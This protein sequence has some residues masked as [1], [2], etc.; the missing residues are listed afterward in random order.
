[1]VVGVVAVLLTAAQPVVGCWI[2]KSHAKEASSLGPAACLAD[3]KVSVLD[4]SALDGACQACIAKLDEIANTEDDRRMKKGM[5][6]CHMGPPGGLLWTASSGRYWIHRADGP[7]CD[8]ICDPTMEPQIGR[9]CEPVMC[10]GDKLAV[11]EDPPP[12]PGAAKFL[13]WE[14]YVCP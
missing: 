12:K 7:T 3:C 9:Y 2:S 6:P 4:P 10:V 5:M 1:M 8:R 14:F 13:R 11:Y